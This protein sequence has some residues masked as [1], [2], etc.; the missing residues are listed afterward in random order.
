MNVTWYSTL[1]W[2]ISKQ[3]CVSS[4]YIIPST[5][6]RKRNVVLMPLLAKESHSLLLV[7][8]AQEV[9]G[10]MSG[11]KDQNCEHPR[12][13]NVGPENGQPKTTVFCILYGNMAVTFQW[14]IVSRVCWHK[15]FST[16]LW[17]RHWDDDAVGT[18]QPWLASHKS[19]KSHINQQKTCRRKLRPGTPNPA[20]RIASKLHLAV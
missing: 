7:A 11:A 6:L 4:L 9:D 5:F 8:E 1:G 13:G 15:C 18:P 3:I 16:S 17:K 19:H 12:Q 2:N 10:S 14:P 20:F